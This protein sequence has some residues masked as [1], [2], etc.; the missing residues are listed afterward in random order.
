MFTVS[1][2]HGLLPSLQGV[3]MGGRAGGHSRVSHL[4]LLLLLLVLLL[5]RIS[6]CSSCS[7]SFCSSCCSMLLLPSVLS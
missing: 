1:G 5:R 7:Y 3:L 2:G 6:C 4:V